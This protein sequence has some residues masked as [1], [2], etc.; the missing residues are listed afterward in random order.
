[1]VT[2]KRHITGGALA[3]LLAAATA[4]AFV[5]R[6]SDWQPFE[7]FVILLVLAIVSDAFHVEFRDMRISGSFLAIVLAMALLGPAPAVVI[8]VVSVIADALR[9]RLQPR[10]LLNNLANYATFP[11]VGGLALR[12][13]S[14]QG[15]EP[16]TVWFALSVLVVFILANALN[17]LIVVTAMLPHSTVSLAR[18]FRQ[19]FIP[20]LPVELATGLL[21]TVI[22]IAYHWLGV[23]ILG[24]VAVVG[25]VFQI[26][27]R[28]TFESVQ[29]GEQLERRTTEL[30]SLQ[31]GLITT[32]L[33]TLSLRDRMT[34]RHSA[35]VARYAREMAKELG[36]PE[37][38]QEVVHTAGLL[39]DIGKFIFPDSILFADTKLTDEEFAIIKKH[40]EQGAKLVRKIEGYG[41]VAE[42]IHAHHERIDGRGYPRGLLG[43]EIPLASKIISI[44]D[45]Y[46]VMTSRDSY[47]TPVSSAEAFAE[48]RRVS[49]AQLDGELVE[50]FIRLV[51][52][53]SIAFR[54]ADDADFE[55]ELN[56]E[57]RVRDYA[58][59][60][61]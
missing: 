40:P 28:T 4:T 10:L 41:P 19:E 8:G 12:W 18:H 30:A 2:Q 33:Q 42:I 29:R 21:T 13:V 61:G 6:A 52:Q 1:M 60:V 38:D 39:H 34:A 22:V 54:H 47:R 51:E 43:P 23:A 44:A 25:L 55:A 36:L 57:R 53:R 56:F 17:F 26:L 9:T 5:S 45:T 14:E 32:V 3:L 15:V 31:V 58:Q 16:T 24:L 49:G 20:M 50:M 59:P 48:L 35:A 46:D 27:L 7:V 37:R 11:L